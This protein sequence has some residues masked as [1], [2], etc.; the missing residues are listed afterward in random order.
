MFWV[1]SDLLRIIFPAIIVYYHNYLCR[2]CLLCRILWDFH[3]KP[4]KLFCQEN[5]NFIIIG[6]YLD[7]F[8]YCGFVITVCSN[9]YM[10]NII[11]IS[12][13]YHGILILLLW[14]YYLVT[15]TFIFSYLGISYFIFMES[16]LLF[17]WL[18]KRFIIVPTYICP[19]NFIL[20]RLSHCL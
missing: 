2:D 15:H 5:S 6:Y 18:T 14:P 4:F 20:S 1:S 11:W 7:F 9:Y 12:F 16:L 19:W 13:C 10:D 8:S 17:F 3:N